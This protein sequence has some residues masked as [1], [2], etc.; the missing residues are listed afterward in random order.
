MLL[1]LC[2]LLHEAGHRCLCTLHALRL[3]CVSSNDPQNA[4]NA[5]DPASPY[6]PSLP[7]LMPKTSADSWHCKMDVWEPLQGKVLMHKAST[8]LC[9]CRGGC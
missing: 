8:E 1:Q 7:L 6:V 3:C 9:A 2:E 5:P 4:L